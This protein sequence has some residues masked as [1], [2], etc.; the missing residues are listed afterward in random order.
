MLGLLLRKFILDIVWFDFPNPQETLWK[1]LQNTKW[2]KFESICLFH[3]DS[4]Q[5]LGNIAIRLF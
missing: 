2:E 3:K 5:G 1:F 4:E